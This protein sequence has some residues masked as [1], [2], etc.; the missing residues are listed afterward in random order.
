M[1]QLKVIN[2]M[3]GKSTNLDI[4][5]TELDNLNCDFLIDFEDPRLK[6]IEEFRS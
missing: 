2:M 1:L 5:A 4:Q 6:Q 3:L